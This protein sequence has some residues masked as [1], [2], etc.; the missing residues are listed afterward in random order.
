MLQRTGICASVDKWDAAATSLLLCCAVQAAL[1]SCY[2][3]PIAHADN[4]LD[5]A[6]LSGILRARQMYANPSLLKC[7]SAPSVPP[8]DIF[9]VSSRQSR[10][11]EVG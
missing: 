9:S 6:T 5:E 2:N 10:L 7:H 3:L 11:D 1:S 8:L 4:L